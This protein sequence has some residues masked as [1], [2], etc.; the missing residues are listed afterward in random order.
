MATQLTEYETDLLAWETSVKELK[1]Q[2]GEV[3][4]ENTKAAILLSSVPP[5]LQ[6]Q[7]QVHSAVDSSYKGL[8]DAL[9]E[10]LMARRTWTLGCWRQLRWRSTP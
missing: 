8:R 3:L 7:M 6:N 9:K 5:E 1:E 2:G 4:S 10:V